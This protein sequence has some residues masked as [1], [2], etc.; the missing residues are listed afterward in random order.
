LQLYL[1][2]A[3]QASGQLRELQKVTADTAYRSLMDLLQNQC[4]YEDQAAEASAKL[5]EMLECQR[6]TKELSTLY[7]LWPVS[8]GE[9]CESKT[10]GEDA[11][12]DYQLPGDMVVKL[13]KRELLLASAKLD[14]VVYETAMQAEQSRRVSVQIQQVMWVVELKRTGVVL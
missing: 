4:K 12:G 5:L 3:S 8:K 11:L 6:E 9:G 10:C 7:E 1:L 2:Q 13:L 14:A